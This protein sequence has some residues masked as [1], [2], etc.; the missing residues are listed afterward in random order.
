MLCISLRL[1]TLWYFAKKNDA[2]FFTLGD[3]ISFFVDFGEQSD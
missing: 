3:V 2:L 1:L